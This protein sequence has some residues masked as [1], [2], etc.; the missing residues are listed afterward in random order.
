MQCLVTAKSPISVD[1]TNGE[2]CVSVGSV[3]AAVGYHSA[4]AS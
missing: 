2:F 4:I 3:V 1:E